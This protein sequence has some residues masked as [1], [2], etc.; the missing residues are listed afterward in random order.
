MIEDYMHMLMLSGVVVVYIAVH[1][2]IIK[3]TFIIYTK[4]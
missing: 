3:I 4:K 2:I 1:S